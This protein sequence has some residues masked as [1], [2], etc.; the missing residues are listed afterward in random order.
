MLGR[1]I[2]CEFVICQEYPLKLSSIT[3]K[4]VHELR[5]IYKMNNTAVTQYLKIPVKQS[6][7]GKVRVGKM[8]APLHGSNAF[9]P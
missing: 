8:S 1:H 9:L 3:N 2:C 4:D 7:D 5:K 6:T